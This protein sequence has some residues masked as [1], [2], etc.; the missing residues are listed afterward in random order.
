[1]TSSWLTTQIY[2]HPSDLQVVLCA[3]SCAPLMTMCPSAPLL[4]STASKLGVTW[5]ATRGP[6]C[7]SSITNSASHT[8]RPSALTVSAFGRMGRWLYV[9]L[10]LYQQAGERTWTARTV[11]V[12]AVWAVWGLLLTIYPGQVAAVLRQLGPAQRHTYHQLDA[13]GWVYGPWLQKERGFIVI[14]SILNVVF[15]LFV[16]FFRCGGSSCLGWLLSLF[17]SAQ[18]PSSP[19]HG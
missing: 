5:P 10:F 2:F 15:C 11:C 14:W 19:S 4:L 17:P 8:S 3:V 6:K 9:L 7:C 12:R 16:L 18:S 1:M 13:T